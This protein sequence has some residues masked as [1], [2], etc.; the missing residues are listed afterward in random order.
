MSLNEEPPFYECTHCGKKLVRKASFDRHECDQMKRLKLCRT[1]KG[2]NAFNDYKQWLS[3]KGKLISKLETFMDSRY[4]NAFI[5]FQTFA[6]EKGIPDKKLYIRLMATLGMSPSLWRSS[7][8]YERYIVE[9]DSEKTPMELV[10]ISLRTLHSLSKIIDCRIH[11][12]YQHMLPSEISRL[13]FE[14]RLS[15]WLLLLSP[16]FLHYLHTVKEPSQHVMITH[17]ID[18]AK[19]QAVFRKN[20]EVVADIK[21]IVS[22]LNL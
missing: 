20:A 3:Y 13:I 16:K 22:E 1:K 12:V 18:P 4:F 19:W 21:K 9:F 6:H 10:D 7:A 14:R 8:L 5:D 11:E 2:F 15:P 17:L